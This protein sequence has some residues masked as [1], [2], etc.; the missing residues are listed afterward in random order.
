MRGDNYEA[1]S[2]LPALDPPPAWPPLTLPALPGAVPPGRARALTRWVLLS[3]DLVQRE[4]ALSGEIE[5][6][7][8]AVLTA[9]QAR[10]EAPLP[11]ALASD[12]SG[13]EPPP[14]LPA[15]A[16][17]SAFHRATASLAR[18]NRS[19]FLLEWVSA[20]VTVR[21]ALA[22]T[23]A[24]ALGLEPAR[25]VVARELEHGTPELDA[26]VAGWT[27][28]R[29]PLEGMRRLLSAMW[30]WVDRNGPWFT[31]HDDEF[32]AYAAKLVLMHRWRRT[33]S[34]PGS[35]GHPMSGARP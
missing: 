22:A 19:R 16:I 23:R 31:F 17:W 20:E 35:G 10:G 18:A 7:E 26:V 24:R 1:L 11:E 25:Y 30:G 4:A 29:D 14:V 12:P 32:A 21:N 5:A 2:S 15:D 27:T 8:P 13:D 9:E 34:G 6:P 28:A 3:D 33:A